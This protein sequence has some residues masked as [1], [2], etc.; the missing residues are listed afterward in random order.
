LASLTQLP[1]SL[2]LGS[3]IDAK[4]IAYNIYGDSAYSDIGSGAFIVLVPDAPISM[5]N[6][7]DVTNVLRIGLEW[8]EGV[9]DNGKPVEDYIVAY[10]QST[11][12]WVNLVTGLTDLT[13]TTTVGLSPGSTY[14]FRVY[15]RSSVGLSLP[16]EIAILCGQKPDAP[17][18]PVTSIDGMN[19]V[20]SWVAPYDGATPITS[21]KV[22]I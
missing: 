11:G 4:V 20:V 22:K 7:L 18:A 12:V 8:E 16:G 5:A 19:L 15:A 9:S 21:Y 6:L 13:Y 14:N 17:E 2:T 1:Y 3:S 10:D